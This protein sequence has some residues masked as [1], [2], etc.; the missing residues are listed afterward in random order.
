MRRAQVA[1]KMNNP[2]EVSLKDLLL[3]TRK[4]KLEKLA[5][6]EFDDLEYRNHIVF[7]DKTQEEEMKRML[8]Q[9]AKQVGYTPKQYSG[10]GI[11]S[12]GYGIDANGLSF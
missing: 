8:A 7:E 3:F 6:K 1:I 12:R 11:S 5:N 10:I 2:S 4:L 9:M